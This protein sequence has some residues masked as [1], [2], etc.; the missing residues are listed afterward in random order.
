MH[1][2]AVV[3]VPPACAAA[4]DKAGTYGEDAVSDTTPQAAISAQA[5][6]ERG[7]SASTPALLWGVAALLLAVG[8]VLTVPTD[9]EWWKVVVLGGVEGVT[10]FLPISSTGHLLVAAQLLHFQ[11]NIGGTF[12]IFIQLGAVVAVVGFYLRDLLAQA[13]SL[14]TSRTTQRFWLG[15]AIAFVPAAVIGLA[16]HKWIKAVLFAPAV[17][18]VSLIVGGIIF[19]VV[20]SLPRIR[21]AQTTRQVERVSWRQALGVGL[22]QTLSLVPGVSRSGSAIVG[23]MF[24]GL[25]RRAATAF[26]FYLAIPTLGAATVV[27]LLTS[28]KDVSASDLGRLY[29]G[30]VVSMIVAWVSIGWLL[31]YVARHTFVA[32]GVYRILA[33]LAILGLLALRWM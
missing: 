32:F 24:G 31:R 25:D 9:P 26:S 18:A 17:I 13:R 27:D 11:H 15:I 4:R 10:E 28:L 1:S 16:L 8:L 22:A 21:Q 30:A 19:I 14:P 20:E 12:E 23:G 3:R 29:L 6:G 2:C 7:K 5:R 33:G